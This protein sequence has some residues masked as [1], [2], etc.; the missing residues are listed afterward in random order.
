MGMLENGDSFFFFT[1]LSCLGII[2]GLYS[3]AQSHRL[4][5]FGV[6]GGSVFLLEKHRMIPVSGQ[7]TFVFAS[8]ASPAF[9]RAYFNAVGVTSL[10]SL[11]MIINLL[12]YICN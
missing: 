3:W 2:N 8:F 10:S 4:P 11:L 6:L 5:Y 9:C 1:F 7:K 12:L